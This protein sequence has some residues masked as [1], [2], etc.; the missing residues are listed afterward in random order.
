MK[1]EANQPLR[2]S[3]RRFLKT[4]LTG[5]A[6]ASFILVNKERSKHI[7]TAQTPRYGFLYNSTLC[8]A[9]NLCHFSCKIRRGFPTGKI[10]P[11]LG[12]ENWLYVSSKQSG[13]LNPNQSGIRESCMHCENAMCQVVCPVDAVKKWNGLVYIDPDRCTGCGYCINACPYGRPKRNEDAECVECAPLGVSRKCDGC[14][15]YV[16]EGLL[17]ACVNACPRGALQFGSRDELITVAQQTVSQN[18]NLYT[19]GLKEYGGLGVL[20]I[21]PQE[22]DP[23]KD[24]GFPEISENNAISIVARGPTLLTGAILGSL[25]LHFGLRK[26]RVKND[27]DELKS[28]VDIE[29]PLQEIT[30]EGE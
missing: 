5:L 11:D 17:P 16:Q 24:A 18:K 14:F 10:E 13:G 19:Y 20:Y 23:V 12:P 22:F 4:S 9:C 3:R 6:A 1:V 26:R 29:D 27:Q 2:V 28:T 7:A 8:N 15:E 25:A 21:F 30:L